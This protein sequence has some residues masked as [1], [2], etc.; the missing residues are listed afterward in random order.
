MKLTESENVVDEIQ[1]HLQHPD[2]VI[3]QKESAIAGGMYQEC[4][5]DAETRV[6]FPAVLWGWRCEKNC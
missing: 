2:N 5:V 3:A 4:G 6:A 1:K